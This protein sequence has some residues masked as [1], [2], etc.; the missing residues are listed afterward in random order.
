MPLSA[1]HVKLQDTL[2]VDD[3]LGGDLP[4]TA[5]STLAELGELVA[6]LLLFG[7]DTRPDGAP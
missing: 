1:A 7:R 2:P 4:A 5:A 6:E 3:V